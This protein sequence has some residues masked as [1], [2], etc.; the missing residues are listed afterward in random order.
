MSNDTS[1]TAAGPAASG[2]FA[3]ATRR[4]VARSTLNGL[5]IWLGEAGLAAARESAGL[6]ATIDQH[7]AA[8]RDALGDP[9]HGPGA[10]PL[11]GY[12]TGVRDALIEAQWQLPP[13]SELDWPALEWPALRLIAICALARAGGFV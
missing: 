4:S 10:V 2:D 13:T 12:A 7:A 3:E 5:M 8:V 11:A 6:Q 9:E 1:Y